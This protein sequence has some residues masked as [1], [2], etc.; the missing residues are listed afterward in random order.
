[1][2][3]ELEGAEE[4]PPVSVVE[5]VPEDGW[6]AYGADALGA[7]GVFLLT[8]PRA[9]RDIARS[10]SLAWRGDA[11]WVYTNP[12]LSASATGLVYRATF[13][14]STKAEAVLAY[15][16]ASIDKSVVGRREGATITIAM[17][18]P[19]RALEWAFSE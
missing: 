3:S 13:E 7:W 12:E 18:A 11:L 15:L 4:S 5:P 1:M 19:N 17:Q 16:P 2:A 8:A 9:G 6:T 10:L 14:D